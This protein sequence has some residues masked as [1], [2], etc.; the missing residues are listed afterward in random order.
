MNSSKLP[1]ISSSVRTTI[2]CSRLGNVQYE[3]RLDMFTEGEG[4]AVT[5]TEA[6]GSAVTFRKAEGSAV[7]F[8]TLGADVT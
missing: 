7:T 3:N 6:E 5:F 8:T 4:S 1:S 2:H